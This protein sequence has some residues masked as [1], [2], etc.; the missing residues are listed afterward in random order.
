MLPEKKS[1]SFS[2]RCTPSFKKAMIE[3]AYSQKI[4]P[5][6]YLIQL[7]TEDLEKQSL[8]PTENQKTFIEKAFDKYTNTMLDFITKNVDKK[9]ASIEALLALKL[10]SKEE[11]VEKI[12]YELEG[13]AHAEKAKVSLETKQRWKKEL[14][15]APDLTLKSQEIRDE[16][17]AKLAE[18]NQQ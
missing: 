7:V 16:I 6:E 12:V 14:N 8:E 15:Q 3:R 1:D 4:E 11:R 13:I 9:M 5:A 17:H 10:L 2:F 18:R